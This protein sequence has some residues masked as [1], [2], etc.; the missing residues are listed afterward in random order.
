MSGQA[1]F[2][3]HVVAVAADGPVVSALTAP[4]G[5]YRI[6]ALPP[7]TYTAYVEPLDGPHGS[8]FLDGCVR[9]GNMG[10]AGI[11][12]AADLTTNFPTT[13]YGGNTTAIELTLEA[14]QIVRA[15]FDLP[16]GTSTLN[17]VRVGPALPDG[18]F[19][20]LAEFPLTLSAG[21]TQWIAIAGPGLDRVDGIGVAGS[22]LTIDASDVQRPEVSCGGESF[23]TMIFP[24]EVGA[25]A[26]PG[27]RTLLVTSGDDLAAFTGA[28]EIGASDE[29]PECV[30]DCDANGAIAV[31]E[32]VRGVNISLDRAALDTCNDFDR[33][34]NQR[35]TI[36]ELIAGVNGLLVGCAEV[37]PLPPPSGRGRGQSN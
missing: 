12:D 5:T 9:F 16:A 20:R 2:G 36:D 29:Q 4:D 35:V 30:G 31:A 14:D 17:P 18:A 22:G 3:A 10:G 33:D 7:G 6:D 27:G 13:F 1:A 24:V 37:L 25:D 26:V 28:V 32:L 11:Y 15:D 8:E 34:S 23:P 19:S 21:A